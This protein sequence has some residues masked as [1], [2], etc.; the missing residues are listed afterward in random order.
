MTAAVTRQLAQAAAG[1]R[2]S[3]LPEDVRALASRCILDGIA[4]AIAGSRD[5]AA[6]IV[7][8]LAIA[9]GGSDEATVVGETVKL[10]AP[11]AAL[12]N[13][14]AAHALDFDDVNVAIPGH[15]TVVVMPAVLAL[16]QRQG[17]SG[18]DAITAFVAGYETA[19][20][21]GRLVG[22]GHYERG[23]HATSTV[24]GIGAAAAAGRL[25]GLAPEAIASAMGVA[26]TQ[27]G[28]LKGLF[29]TMAKPLHAGTASRNGVLAAQLAVRGFDAGADALEKVQ[30]F[31][32]T[33]S[34]DMRPEA[35]LEDPRAFRIRDNLFKFHVACYGTHAAIDCARQIATSHHLPPEAIDRV[36]VTANPASDRYC[37]IAEPADGT[38]AKF[39]LRLAA[40]LGLLG[41]DTARLDAYEAAQFSRPEVVRL[42]D[43]C[44]VVFEANFAMMECRVEVRT[45][46]GKTYSAQA[47]AGVP[48]VDRAVQ[49]RR[50]EA[51]FDTLVGPAIGDEQSAR[52]KAMVL[53]LDQEPDLHGIG[54][55]LQ[56]FTAPR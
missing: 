10:P 30:G 45:R 3:E 50:V 25:L 31:A 11:Q 32:W 37:N 55:V 22:P 19:C 52:L 53:A 28:G 24:G 8:E 26:A 51:K 35:A 23:H 17:A 21:V 54:A 43:R 44:D 20:R 36:T 1:Y 33:L 5:P 27:A 47:D 9:D 18:S 14:T 41:I 7:R 48:E 4:C 46:D 15:V 49:A 34:P 38:Q 13:A 56:R 39:S 29:G 42:R 2:Y 40:A 12:V 6:R 16:A